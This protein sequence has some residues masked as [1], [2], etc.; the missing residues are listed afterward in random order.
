MNSSLCSNVS[1]ASLQYDLCVAEA[2]MDEVVCPDPT[3]CNTTLDG[4]NV[5]L[6]FGLTIGAGLATTIGALMPFVPCIKRANTRFLAVGLALAAGVMLYVSFTEIWKK[7]RDNFC[8]VTPD[9][10]DLAVTACFFGGIVITIL[11][12]LVVAGLQ[13]I[14]CGCCLPPRW[15]LGFK[16]RPTSHRWCCCGRY[17]SGKMSLHGNGVSATNCTLQLEKISRNGLHNQNGLIHDSPSGGD[18]SIACGSS[19]ARLPSTHETGCL[20]NGISPASGAT[21]PL[22][23]MDPQDAVSHNPSISNSDWAPPPP[24]PPLSSEQQSQ[25][26][27]ETDSRQIVS[28]TTPDGGSISVNSIA[29]SEGTNNYATTSVNELFSNSSLL[30][31][32][33]I[34]P[35]TESL[36][37]AE[38][39]GVGEG[40]EKGD[41]LTHVSVQVEGSE[42]TSDGIRQRNNV[43]KEMVS[44]VPKMCE[45]PRTHGL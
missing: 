16:A 38:G 32:N 43:Y 41:S 5:G 2:E 35:E 30:R 12:D 11:L 1:V 37:L 44:S 39:E 45:R 24:P 42:G 22:V 19:N 17:S 29:P 26:A 33:A 15:R 34:I 10:M 23:G 3:L 31:M 6:A 18:A 7:S 21:N 40:G 8:C 28:V 20:A 14:D 27:S 36:S 25:L 9:H 4:G 13:R